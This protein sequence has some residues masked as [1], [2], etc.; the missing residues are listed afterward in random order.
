LPRARRPTLLRA[1]AAATAAAPSPPP[2]LASLVLPGGAGRVEVTPLLP[3]TSQQA[4]PLDAPSSDASAA[5]VVVTRAFAGTAEQ[6]RLEDARTFVRRLLAVASA[7]AEAQASGVV[8][9][10][11]R[12]RPAVLLVAKLLPQ[13]DEEE[14]ATS[15]DSAKR[16]RRARVAGVACVSL[17]AGD[18]SRTEQVGE[19]GVTAPPADEPYLFNVAVDPGLRRK[20]IAT[21]LVRAAEQVAAAASGGD[22][23]GAGVRSMW[24]HV[25]QADP[26][27]QA[28]YQRAGYE[29]V[30]RDGPSSL[31]SSGGPLGGMLGALFGGGGK[32]ASAASAA[33]PRPRIL[34]RRA[35]D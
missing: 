2:P 22:G 3:D 19:E 5:A 35:L 26:A 33:P 23:S 27:A 16:K 24:L 34:M 31:S 6:V 18:G 15:G 28:L 32:A 10:D 17:E 29:E 8:G 4:D 12:P 7:A 21:A 25:R 11:P 1:P 9:A 13:D 30:G 20:G 14:E